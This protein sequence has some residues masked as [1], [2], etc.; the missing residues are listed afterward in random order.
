MRLIIFKR[1]NIELP[2]NFSCGISLELGLER[3]TLTRY[4]G[5]HGEHPNLPDYGYEAIL[6]DT[7]HIHEASELAIIEGKRLE[8]IAIPTDSYND[9]D[10]AWRCLVEDHNVVGFDNPN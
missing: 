9:F 8:Y 2:E 3:Y 6:P 1:Q 4:N 5:H 7:C 10:G